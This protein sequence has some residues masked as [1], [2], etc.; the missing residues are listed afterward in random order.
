MACCFQEVVPFGG[1]RDLWVGETP[2]VIVNRNM[3]AQCYINGILQLT[4]LPFLQ[5]QPHGVIY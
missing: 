3:T 4:V 2:L 1:G 5:Q